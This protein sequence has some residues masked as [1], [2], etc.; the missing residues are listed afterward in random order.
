MYRSSLLFETPTTKELWLS[1]LMR[2]RQAVL[3]SRRGNATKLLRGTL[4]Q[5]TTQCTDSY[6]VTIA[7][8]CCMNWNNVQLRP[9]EVTHDFVFCD[10][11]WSKAKMLWERSLTQVVWMMEWMSVVGLAMRVQ[12]SAAATEEDAVVEWRGRPR[13][14]DE[15]HSISC[16]SCIKQF[17]ISTR[18]GHFAKIDFN[19]LN[20]I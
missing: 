7:A 13:C 15:M 4:V 11:V 6:T 3:I 20:A 19:R 9:V 8:N 14:S 10:Y 17:D 1:R 18:A 2:Y 5:K 12:R 16:V